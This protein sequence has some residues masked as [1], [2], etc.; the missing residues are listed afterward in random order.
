MTPRQPSGRAT[1]PHQLPSSLR[2]SLR[3]LALA[4]QHPERGRRFRP[5]RPWPRE[6][7]DLLTPRAQAQHM[8]LEAR[9]LGRALDVILGWFAQ[10]KRTA[11]APSYV[12]TWALAEARTHNYLLGPYVGELLQAVLDEDEGAGTPRVTWWREAGTAPGSGRPPAAFL[13]QATHPRYLRVA[14]YG[15]WR[16]AVQFDRRWRALAEDW[17]RD[18]RGVWA[19]LF[20]FEKARWDFHLA[21]TVSEYVFNA[22]HA[23]LYGCGKG[24]ALCMARRERLGGA[25]VGA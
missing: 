16:A 13:P 25:E 1:L 21:C 19:M 18:P 9:E 3:A 15:L 2:R 11:V 14:L 8:Q 4:Y 7:Y 6:V 10:G 24:C 20:R 5:A 12:E 22:W 23:R 17:P